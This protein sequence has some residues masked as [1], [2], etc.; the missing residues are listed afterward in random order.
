[1]RTAEAGIEKINC[2]YRLYIFRIHSK[3]PVARQAVFFIARA[4]EAAPIQSFP[5]K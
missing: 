2:L 4:N 1:M 3:P 5:A